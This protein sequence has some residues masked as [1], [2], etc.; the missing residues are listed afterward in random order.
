M[1][2]IAEFFTAIDAAWSST[3][4]VRLLIIGSGALMMQ[5]DYVRGT[6][7]GDVLQTSELSAEH[8]E[9]LRGIAGRGT[10]FHNK[11]GMYIDIVDNGIPFL[12]RVPLFHA[13]P[14]LD[15]TLSQLEIRALDVIDVVVGKLKPF[16]PRDR[17]D[18]RAMV[19][20]GLVSHAR[21]VERFELAADELCHGSNAR[22]VM[23]YIDNL[24]SIER[25]ILLVDESEIRLPSWFDR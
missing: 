9:Q 20:R 13:V 12:P 14:S 3:S 10:A 17:D 5:T 18:I 11:H 24:H 7:D 6:N 22:D 2:R 16:R 21:L 15:A 25:D 1:Q 8:A 19:D 23:K 4:K